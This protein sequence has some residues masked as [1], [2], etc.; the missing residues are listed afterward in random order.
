MLAA[1]A[2]RVGLHYIAPGGTA[3]I[4]TA[5]YLP[6]TASEPTESGPPCV[7]WASFDVAA[8]VCE[9]FDGNLV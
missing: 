5:T 9:S 8:K 6:P 1:H 7:R 2:K 4:T 3:L